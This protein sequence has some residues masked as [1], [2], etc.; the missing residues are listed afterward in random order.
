MEFSIYDREYC[1]CE[2]TQPTSEE[3]GYVHIVMFL[4]LSVKMLVTNSTELQAHYIYCSVPI[5]EY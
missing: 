4:Y 5:K 3:I 1:C 2:M